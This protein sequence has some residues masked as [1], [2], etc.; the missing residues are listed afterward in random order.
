MLFRSLEQRGQ[1]VCVLS[2]LDPARSIRP[3]VAEGETPRRRRIRRRVDDRSRRGERTGLDE[4]MDKAFACTD[5]RALAARKLSSIDRK[6]ADLA[7]MREALGG[8]LRQCDAGTGGA[9]CPIIDVL[10][11]D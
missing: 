10:A 4:R 6:M 5:T 7:A 8:L 2:G 1:F 3:A 9:A 11:L